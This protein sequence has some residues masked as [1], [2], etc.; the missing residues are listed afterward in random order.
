M[1]FFETWKKVLSSPSEFY[2]SMPISGGY[3]EPFKFAVICSIPIM[4]LNM[5]WSLRSGDIMELLITPPKHVLSFALGLLIITTFIFISAIVF[6]R[7]ENKGFESIFRIIS[8][9]N[10]LYSIPLIGHLY[11]WIL[12]IIGLREVFKVSTFRAVILTTALIL[13]L[14]GGITVASV[15]FYALYSR[16]MRTGPPL[17]GLS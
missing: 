1:T 17:P 3:L 7:K 16:Y 5:L 12:T 9:S 8:Y 13:A 2:S 6:A 11:G 4:V 14:I 15:V 10:V